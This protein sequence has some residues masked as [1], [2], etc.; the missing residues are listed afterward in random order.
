MAQFQQQKTGEFVDINFDEKIG[1]GGQGNVY[2]INKVQGYVAKIY[3]YLNP[4]LLEKLQVMI[5]NPRKIPC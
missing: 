2:K 4:D 1:G 5:D 3:S